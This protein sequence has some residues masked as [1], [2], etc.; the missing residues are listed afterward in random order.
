MSPGWVQAAAFDRSHSMGER[1]NCTDSQQYRIRLNGLA[2]C[3][4]Q[5]GGRPE[6]G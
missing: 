3:E 1:R 2:P 6:L 4:P 5:I